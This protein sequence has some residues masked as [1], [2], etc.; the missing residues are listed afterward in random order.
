VITE[1][2]NVKKKGE[3][4]KHI[5]EIRPCF[6]AASEL[7]SSL[8]KYIYSYSKEE[9]S[10]SKSQHSLYQQGYAMICCNASILAHAW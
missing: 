6:I 3:E 1:Q 9:I 10:S 4:K 8:V 2:K 7:V 5:H